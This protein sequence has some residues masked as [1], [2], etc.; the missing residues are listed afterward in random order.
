MTVT[1]LLFAHLRDRLGGSVVV[2]LPDG[3]TVADLRRAAPL[4]G[5]RVAVNHAFADDDRVIS[6]GDE[7]AAIPPV[8]G[9]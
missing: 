4:D 6:A 1:V 5:C 9:G 7:V 3:G 8:S 2:E